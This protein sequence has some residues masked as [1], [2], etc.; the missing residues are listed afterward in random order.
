MKRHIIAGFIATFVLAGVSGIGIAS[1]QTVP[2]AP[3]AST[4]VAQTQSPAELPKPKPRKVFAVLHITPVATYNVGGADLPRPAAL[5]GA[6][7]NFQYA[8]PAVNLGYGANINIAPHW[9]LN[10]VHGFVNQ[11]LGTVTNYAGET[12][13][14]VFNNDRTDDASLGYA[15]GK[16][17][18]SA[19]WH[20]RVR[21]CCANGPE[22]G[23][24]ETTY[25]Y[26]Y[27]QAATRFGPG[28][29][30]FGGLFG[31]TVQGAYE[32]HVASQAYYA[33]PACLAYAT[34]AQCATPPFEIPGEG[35]KFHYLFAGNV[36]IPIGGRNSS[37]AIFGTYLNNWDY[38]NNSPIMYLYNEADYGFIKKFSPWVTLTATNSNLYQ[39]QEGYPFVLPNVIN[40]NKLIVS[41]DVALPVY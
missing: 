21:M 16:F 34:K 35:N 38:Y 10:F 7:G 24:S 15:L 39:H 17:S 8:D 27:A 30:Y 32:P 37:F 23:A 4:Q 28:S 20:E 3:G 13:Y 18:L 33:N 9:T 41:L 12:V 31:L 2:A 6:T 40:R 11:N 29:K 26:W 25:H 5:G 14:Q 1:A 36:T 19:G 22:N